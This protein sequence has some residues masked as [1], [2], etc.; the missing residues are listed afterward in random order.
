MK[1]FLSLL[2]VFG[3]LLF[4]GCDYE[5]KSD[6]KESKDD[7]YKEKYY[8]HMKDHDDDKKKHKKGHHKHDE[9]HHSEGIFEILQGLPTEVSEDE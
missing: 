3:V 4:V 8:D 2:T 7:G 9:D 5:K 1:K 6:H